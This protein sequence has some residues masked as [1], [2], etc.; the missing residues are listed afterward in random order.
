MREL[1]VN[2]S[3]SRKLLQELHPE[4]Q[5]Y[6]RK[7][8]MRG[9][10]SPEDALAEFNSLKSYHSQFKK[11]VL[12]EGSSYDGEDF[13][14]Q[15]II[16]VAVVAFFA[17]MYFLLM[18]EQFI[19]FLI[20]IPVFVL[21]V[22]LFLFYYNHFIWYDKF[23]D[24]Y[25]IE[26][27]NLTFLIPILAILREEVKPNTQISLELDLKPRIKSK[28]KNVRHFKPRQNITAQQSTDYH[29]PKLNL[30][31]RLVDGTSFHLKLSDT[32]ARQKTTKV[33]ARRKRKVKRKYKVKTIAN[34]QL[35]FSKQRNLDASRRWNETIELE[36]ESFDNNF[37]KMLLKSGKKPNSIVFQHATWMTGQGN[38]V[39]TNALPHLKIENF[40]SLL[41]QGMSLVFKSK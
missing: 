1:L 14:I 21:C 27:R 25:R 2:L 41:R 17:A 15:V 23:I 36:K 40:L 32:I 26:V 11:E 38:E 19:Y 13:I 9:E 5:E 4:Q 34:L 12:A 16:L 10:F 35:K 20:C 37:E 8:I 24:P 22:L 3:K 39:A 31:A 29:I 28:H 30:Q 18:S 33:N 7:G 6:I